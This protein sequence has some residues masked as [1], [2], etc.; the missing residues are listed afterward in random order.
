MFPIA[1]IKECRSNPCENGGTC[2]DKL[3]GYTCDC[4]SSGFGG[5]HCEQG[6]NK[7]R[8]YGDWHKVYV[9]EIYFQLIYYMSLVIFFNRALLFKYSSLYCCVGTVAL[10]LLTY[11]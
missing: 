2:V 7:F 11:H 4:G 1:E 3:N 6:L 8:N 10:A 5:F 9:S